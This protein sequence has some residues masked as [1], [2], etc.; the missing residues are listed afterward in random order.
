MTTVSYLERRF[1][2][3][4]SIVST[5]V[6]D[7]VILVPIR[8]KTEDIKSAYI[9]NEVASRIWALIDG[10]RRVAEIRDVIVEEFEVSTE[11]VE[12]DLIE[13]MQQLEQIEAVKAV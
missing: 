11:E 2:K 5:E 4:P 7:E 13:F 6:V 8:Q 12:A 3:D 9:I 1:I 10:E